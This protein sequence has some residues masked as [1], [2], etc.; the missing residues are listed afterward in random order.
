M[1]AMF[2][3]I[4][5]LLASALL[6]PAFAEEEFEFASACETAAR[7]SEASAGGRI[8]ACLAAGLEQAG[9]AGEV[10]AVVKAPRGEKRG[11][12]QA[13]S[14]QSRRVIM[15]CTRRGRDKREG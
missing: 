15:G 6:S 8:C 2:R 12:M 13:A 9:D 10:I 14:E 4:A 5:L 7:A 11:P 3:V 1:T